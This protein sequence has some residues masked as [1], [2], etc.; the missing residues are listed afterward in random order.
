[1]DPYNSL[2]N[3]IKFSKNCN[4]VNNIILTTPEYVD[5]IKNHPKNVEILIYACVFGGSY[6][7]TK[8]IKLI[9]SLG[10]DINKRNHLGLSAIVF[11]SIFS[12]CLSNKKIIEYLIDNGA[13][14]YFDAMKQCLACSIS[15]NELIKMYKPNEYYNFEFECIADD[16]IVSDISVLDLFLEKGISIDI[17]NPCGRTLLDFFILSSIV[18]DEN[19]IKIV[20]YLLNHGSKIFVYANTTSFLQVYYIDVKYRKKILKL[21]LNKNTD[22]INYMDQIGNSVIS[23][24][25][26]S[27]TWDK[28][29]KEIKLLLDHGVSE[30]SNLHSFLFCGFIGNDN[31]KTINYLI[32]RNYKFRSIQEI[33][34]IIL[35]KIM[36]ND[37]V[38][39]YIFLSEKLQDL[40]E[41]SPTNEYIEISKILI[42]CK[43]FEQNISSS[44]DQKINWLKMC[45]FD[46]NFN[47]W[48][49][50]ILISY[51]DPN[52]FNFNKINL[53][54][55]HGIDIN[56]IDGIGK[57]CIDYLIEKSINKGTI[58]ATKLLLNHGANY[59]KIFQKPSLLGMLRDHLP[60]SICILSDIVKK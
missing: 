32:K 53:L 57:T 3:L 14:Q 35:W 21:I 25:L 11:A 51:V 17:K 2:L 7:S 33:K 46:I 28:N 26:S 52:K 39:D 24:Y 36:G 5:V 19:K 43:C 41:P 27:N 9:L 56:F 37:N 58:S 34:A 20:K 31:P 59:F 49:S 6:S 60:F 4:V 38:K 29:I 55:K 1:M 44:V 12:N 16:T 40:Y 23:L 45:N 50:N 13:T 18:I 47:Y 8:T 30:D 54:I 48:R 22:N 15:K 42:L 10:V